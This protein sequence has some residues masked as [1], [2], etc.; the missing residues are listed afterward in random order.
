MNEFQEIDR[1]IKNK[2]KII[3]DLENKSKAIDNNIRKSRDEIVS[4]NS[5]IK[6]KI[7]E[8]SQV[9]KDISNSKQEAKQI[10]NDARAIRKESE[11]EL[12]KVKDLTKTTKATLEELKKEKDQLEKRSKKVKEEKKEANDLI[13][14][15]TAKTELLKDKG[16]ALD[17]TIKQFE[18]KVL[19]ADSIQQSLNKDRQEV[20]A[21]RDETKNIKEEA[22]LILNNMRLDKRKLASQINSIS[23]REREHEKEKKDCDNRS[24][25][26]FLDEREVERKKQSHQKNVDACEAYVSMI[27]AKEKKADEIINRGNK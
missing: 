17:V 18:E 25:K 7:E 11:N 6:R 13:N 5:I 8:S 23:V 14:E 24:S 20:I 27:K 3:F 16:K 19:D 1:T 9:D 22:N 12:V 4:L 10:V 21:T 15:Y 2:K 26:L